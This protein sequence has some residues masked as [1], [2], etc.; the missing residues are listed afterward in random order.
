MSAVLL[1]N[2]FPIRAHDSDNGPRLPGCI[3]VYSPTQPRLALLELVAVGFCL[4][5]LH[6]HHGGDL[7][8]L[9]PVARAGEPE[10]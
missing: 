1:S 3:L 10:R 5:L 9:F 8:F 2:W 4:F 7:S 6:H